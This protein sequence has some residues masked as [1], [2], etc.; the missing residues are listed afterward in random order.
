MDE[1]L[2]RKR[3]SCHT[4][5]TFPAPSISADG[6]GPLRRPPATVCLLTALIVTGA[7]QVE[8]PLVERKAR[9]DVSVALAI[10]S[11]VLILQQPGPPT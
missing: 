2:V 8:P 7:P 6:N 9:I 5:K 1:Q 11:V 4:T 3:Q 10:V